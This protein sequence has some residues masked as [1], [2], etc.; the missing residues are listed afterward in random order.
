MASSFVVPM[1]YKILFFNI[2]VLYFFFFVKLVEVKVL[3]G[4]H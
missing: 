4:N 3:N 2:F 1:I